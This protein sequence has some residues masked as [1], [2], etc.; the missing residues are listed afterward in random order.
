VASILLPSRSLGGDTPASFL[1]DLVR[2]PHLTV[3]MFLVHGHC[4]SAGI[5]Q[6]VALISTAFS[7]SQAVLG[8]AQSLILVVILDA[9]R[10]LH[11]TLLVCLLLKEPALLPW[12]G[13]LPSPGLRTIPRLEAFDQ[14]ALSLP[15]GHARRQ[16]LCTHALHFGPPS[17]AFDALG[18]LAFRLGPD[19]L[20]RRRYLVVKCQR[21]MQ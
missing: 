4:P 19:T 20:T 15:L 8:L 7:P 2:S 9:L 16:Q 3:F 18:E 17:F 1:L 12:V 6:R 14:F 10:E 13:R 21:L 11:H 5:C